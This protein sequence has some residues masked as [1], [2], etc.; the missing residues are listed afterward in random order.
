[1]R[2]RLDIVKVDRAGIFANVVPATKAILE[3]EKALTAEFQKVEQAIRDLKSRTE[4]GEILT[5]ISI[6]EHDLPQMQFGV[7]V[8]F[9]TV[10]THYFS[11]LTQEMLM[12]QKG[13]FTSALC[14]PLVKH[15][16]ADNK[17][18]D[19]SSG[20]WELF[21]GFHNSKPK[22]KTKYLKGE[23]LSLDRN[24]RFVMRSVP[25]WILFF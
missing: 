21:F 8:D 24:S 25:A 3:E 19:Y 20:W 17:G 22:R 10:D 11:L 12:N 2:H 18:H 7:S 13:R 6:F 4:R 14:V 1:M 16:M 5:A 15:E 23:T 9:Q